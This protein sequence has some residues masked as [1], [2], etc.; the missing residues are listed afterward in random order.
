MTKTYT[1]ICQK[2]E[3]ERRALN[4]MVEEFEYED[5]NDDDRHGGE[6]CEAWVLGWTTAGGGRGRLWIFV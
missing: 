4:A 3:R 5:D 1:L 2:R 6:V